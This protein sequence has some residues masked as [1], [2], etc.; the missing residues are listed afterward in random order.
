MTVLIDPTDATR[1]EL[2][3]GLLLINREAEACHPSPRYNDLHE[4]INALLDR[5][6]GL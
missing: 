3:V 1:D 6:V 5:L 4:T 2:I